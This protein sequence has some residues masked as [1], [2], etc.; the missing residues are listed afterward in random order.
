MRILI[1]VCDGVFDQRQV[2]FTNAPVAARAHAYYYFKVMIPTIIR[3]RRGSRRQAIEKVCTCEWARER[4]SGHL[5]KSSGS[6]DE[7]VSHSWLWHNHSAAAYCICWFVRALVMLILASSHPRPWTRG[8]NTLVCSADT[9]CLTFQ[10]HNTVHA[11]AC[12]TTPYN[13][14]VYGEL[15]VCCI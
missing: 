14:M 9:M 5:V 2:R 7:L 15:T 13:Y 11:P 6:A 4:S 3:A 8:T 10:W 1:N 12:C